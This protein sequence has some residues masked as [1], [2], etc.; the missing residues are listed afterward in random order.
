MPSGTDGGNGTAGT[1]PQMLLGLSGRRTGPMCLG[2]VRP[3]T[4]PGRNPQ[5]HAKTEP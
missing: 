1:G 4:D 5:A 3:D 2:P